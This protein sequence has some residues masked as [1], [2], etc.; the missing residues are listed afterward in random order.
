LRDKFGARTLRMR[1]G[2]R[3]LRAPPSNLHAGGIMPRPTL[4]GRIRTTALLALLLA[5][6]SCGS[7]A[8]ETAPTPEDESGA[9]SAAGRRGRTVG[10]EDLDGGRRVGQ[11]EE[12]LEGRFAGVRVV[13]LP[14]GAIAVRIRGATSVNGSN[15]PLYVVD[16]VPI[17]AGP[18]GALTGINPADITKIEIL[19]DI[20]STSFY[21]VRGAN[22]VVLISTR[23]N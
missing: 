3:I 23:R 14:G 16:G 17:E 13:R 22:G 4:A 15:D 10:Q 6:A 11:A 1:G 12:L 19:K 18:G 5:A 8:P 2:M 20:G 21:G 9:S 7:A